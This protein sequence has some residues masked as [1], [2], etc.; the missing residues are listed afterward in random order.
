ML[1]RMRF[2]RIATPEGMTFAVIDDAGERAKA[3]TGTPF[4]QPEYTGKEW[5]LDQV[6][7]LAPT[8]PSKIVAVGRNYADHV[9]E[10]F[11]KSADDLPPTI[12]IKP[13]TA[14]VGPDAAIKIPDFAT[15]VEFEGE[16]ALV[17]GVPCKN[18]AAENWK[19]VIRGVTIINDVSSRDLQFADGQ[20][21]RAKGMDTFGPL[22]PWIETDLEKFDFD[23]LPI[24]A[25]LTHDGVTETKQDSNSNQMIKK[26]GEIVEWVSQSFT[27]LPGDVIATGSPAGTAVM[28]PGD[29]IEVEIPGIG[30]LRNP[31]ERA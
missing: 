11:K 8:L 29:T 5:S 27:L 17:V 13:P 21:A 26:I 10:V 4:T 7:L 24:K 15:G 9:A 19:S 6:R 16:L 1:L 22:G 18:V 14:V 25:H 31:V 23:D 30:T 28:V 20:W 3:I 2:G 12:F